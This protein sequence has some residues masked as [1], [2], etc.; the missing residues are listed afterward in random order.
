MSSTG[1]G[2]PAAASS[3]AV[4]MECIF[5]LYETTCQNDLQVLP[6]NEEFGLL[7]LQRNV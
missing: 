6:E 7:L 2:L 5:D 4:S 3:S 1:P